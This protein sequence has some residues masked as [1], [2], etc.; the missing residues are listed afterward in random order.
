M[1]NY[2]RGE[3]T[4]Y[5]EAM[6]NK[7]EDLH[8]KPSSLEMHTGNSCLGNPLSI[9]RTGYCCRAS[10]KVTCMLEKCLDNLP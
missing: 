5:V 3:G 2:I 9:F 4:C 10:E 6:P 7:V 1:K 8:R